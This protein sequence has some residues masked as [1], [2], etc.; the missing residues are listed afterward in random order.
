MPSIL[1]GAVVVLALHAVVAEKQSTTRKP[2]VLINNMRPDFVDETPFK[3]CSSLDGPR[4][5]ADEKGRYMESRALAFEKKRE[6]SSSEKELLKRAPLAQ[7]KESKPATSRAARDPYGYIDHLDEQG[8]TK[9]IAEL[10]IQ[11]WPSRGRRR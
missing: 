6:E 3:E 5:S 1:V 8:A 7:R 10:K 2:N 4:C 11:V 9:L